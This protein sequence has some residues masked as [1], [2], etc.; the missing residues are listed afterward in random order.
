ML[1]AG[2]LGWCL[3]LV[4]PLALAPV[5]RQMTSIRTML[6][7]RA[8]LLAGWVPCIAAA[9][10]IGAGCCR[11]VGDATLACSMVGRNQRQTCATK[12]TPGRWDAKRPDSMHTAQACALAD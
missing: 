6:A 10:Q 4:R 7:V 2:A 5:R 8:V 9:P 3:V 11:I 12:A 1:V